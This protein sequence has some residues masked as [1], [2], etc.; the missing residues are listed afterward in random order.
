MLRIQDEIKG[1]CSPI[2]KRRCN[3]LKLDEVKKT[4][5]NKKNNRLSTKQN[6]NIFR[7]GKWGSKET[8]GQKNGKN[9]PNVQP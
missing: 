5:L 6:N 1:Q 7:K 4:F 9:R 2:Y 8:N 3:K